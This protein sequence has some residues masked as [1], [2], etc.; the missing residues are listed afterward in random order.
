MWIGKGV[1]REVGKMA[2]GGDSEELVVRTKT[3][4]HVYFTLYIL[5]GQILHFDEKP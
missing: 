1:Y 3:I 2:W 4:L 5:Y